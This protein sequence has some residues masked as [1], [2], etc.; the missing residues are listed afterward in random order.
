M[1]HFLACNLCDVKCFELDRNGCITRIDCIYLFQ[2]RPGLWGIH[3]R[4]CEHQPA[5]CSEDNP[6]PSRC[7]RPSGWPR[8][9]C[10]CAPGDRSET[11]QD[12]FRLISRSETVY[13]T[14]VFETKSIF[15]ECTFFLNVA[16][17]IWFGRSFIYCCSNIIFSYVLFY[18]LPMICNNT[19]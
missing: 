19:L 4:F 14:F 8:R 10:H 1:Q 6:S 12:W 2:L 16:T 17:H 18:V 13:F 9:R 15:N 11:K 7:T 3:R 5:W